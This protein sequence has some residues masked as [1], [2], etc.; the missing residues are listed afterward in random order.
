MQTKIIRAISAWS[1][2]VIVGLAWVGWL[3]ASDLPSRL[4]ITHTLRIPH[5]TITIDFSTRNG[6]VEAHAKTMHMAGQDARGI[7]EFS[8]D[9]ALTP[10]Q[11]ARLRWLF[12]ALDLP[13][14]RERGPNAGYYGDGANW[15]LSYRD[16]QPRLASLAAAAEP[17]LA[18][19]R[20]E[21]K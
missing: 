12:M 1:V 17:A 14:L 15:S 6:V 21:A 7:A 19:V 8:K 13:E 5:N 2:V 16:D 18:L 10:E 4:V 11:S 20:C 3:Q 9:H